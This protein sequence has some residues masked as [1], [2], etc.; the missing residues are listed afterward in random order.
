M[1]KREQT[2][3]ELTGLH[4]LFESIEEEFNKGQ[5]DDNGDTVIPEESATRIR[6]LLEM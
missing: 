4:Q 2:E 3:Q 1:N 5:I 6:M